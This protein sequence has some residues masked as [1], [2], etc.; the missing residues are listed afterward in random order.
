MLETQLSRLDE[1]AGLRPSRKSASGNGRA[2]QTTRPTAG[3][4]TGTGRSL[5][6]LPDPQHRARPP[7]PRVSPQLLDLYRLLL[8]RFACREI[9]TGGAL[10][11]RATADT[12]SRQATDQ[13]LSLFLA[14]SGQ[15]HRPT[16]LIQFI[17]IDGGE[18]ST[19]L[20]RRF[21]GVC[22]EFTDACVLLI[23]REA[24]NSSAM[25]AATGVTAPWAEAMTSALA[26][27]DIGNGGLFACNWQ[28]VVE[29][30]AADSD[31]DDPVARS[32]ALIELLRPAFQMMILDA[33]PALHAP[34]SLQVCRFV[35]AVVLVIDARK[36]TAA[37]A[38]SAIAR[39]RAAGGNLV[40]TVL[41]RH[42]S[43]R[44]SL[45]FSSF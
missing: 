32:A 7:A 4:G 3:P 23:E 21:A 25:P 13:F 18:G 10:F 36:T 38:A 43:P 31:E 29:A 34:Q 35:D 2:L 19:T 15:I 44:F 14:I 28:K 24:G 22:A 9:P 20:A 27:A 6:P 17:G 8:Q 16:P 41:N 30:T 11:N 33:G 12:A 26:L 40:G 42:T 45:R 1:P 37:A 5:I 39:V